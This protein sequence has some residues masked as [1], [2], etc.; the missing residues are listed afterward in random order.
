MNAGWVVHRG[1]ER[2][3]AYSTR[4]VVD[5]IRRKRLSPLD[6]IRSADN[7]DGWSAQVWAETFG[8]EY[9][10]RVPAIRRKSTAWFRQS[11]QWP[12]FRKLVVGMFATSVFLNWVG[13]ALATLVAWMAWEL[14]SGRFR[15]HRRV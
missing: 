6:R 15:E 13:L 1:G 2:I 10:R 5:L 7:S 8:S 9:E 3:G 14:W 11:E 4:E 12:L